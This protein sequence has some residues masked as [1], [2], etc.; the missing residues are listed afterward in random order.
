MFRRNQNKK[1]EEF[2]NL[3]GTYYKVYKKGNKFIAIKPDDL[4][5]TFIIF[6]KENKGQVENEKAIELELGINTVKTTLEEIFKHLGIKLE[7]IERNT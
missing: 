1:I 4:G 2:F 5:Y 6:G 7:E 3:Y